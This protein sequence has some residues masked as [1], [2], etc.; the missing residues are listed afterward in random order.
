MGIS[1]ALLVKSV[2]LRTKA[3]PALNPATVVRRNRAAIIGA[4]P[5]LLTLIV[6]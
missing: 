3:N 1:E 2:P 6:V 5:N 4:K